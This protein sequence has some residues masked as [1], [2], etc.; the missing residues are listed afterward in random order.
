[1]HNLNYPTFYSKFQI[2]VLIVTASILFS[3]I[4][5]AQSNRSSNQP[6]GVIFSVLTQQNVMCFGGNNGSA[7]ITQPTGGTPP[8]TI[9]W[10]PGNPTGDGTTSITGLTAGIWTCTVTDA[11]GSFASLTFTITQ[12]LSLLYMSLNQTNVGCV[13]AS[14]GSANVT[15]LGGSG[16]YTYLWLPT[17]ITFPTANG[18]AAGIHYCTVTDVNNCQTTRSITIVEQPV[19]PAPTGSATQTLCGGATIANLVATGSNIKW[20][21][22]ATGG[23]ALTANTVLVNGSTYYASQTI[24]TC[25]GA[26]RLAVTATTSTT[27]G[28][29]LAFDGID[30]HITTTGIN[31]SNQSFTIEFWAKRGSL[32]GAAY[33]DI[34]SQGGNISNGLFADNQ[35]L[36][37][38]FLTDDKL[39][40]DFWSN[41]VTST[42]AIIDLVNWHHYALTFDAVTKQ[43]SIYIDGVLNNSRTSSANYSGT[44]V[45]KI[46]TQFNNVN[47]YNGKLDEFR[48]WAR[49]L[50]QTEIQN[51]SIGELPSNTCSLLQNL[52]FNQGFANGDNTTIASVVDSSGNGYNGTLNGFSKACSNSTSNFVSPGAVTSGALLAINLPGASLAFDGVDDYVSTE[53]I[54]ISNQSFS[55][56]FWAKRGSLS[57]AAY[58]D[59]ASQG[60]PNLNQG[61]YLGFLTD[62]K[63]HFDFWGNGVTSTTA[64]TDLVN[65]H[66]YAFT[67]NAATKVQSI[68]IDGVLNNSHLG[69]GNYQGAGTFY[70]GKQFN[71]VNY[72]KGQIDEFRI[73]NNVLN[74]LQIQNQRN[75]EIP[76]NTCGLIQ[77]LH[78]NQGVSDGDNIAIT[79]VTDASGYN[80]NGTLNN[81]SKSCGNS[82]SNFTK[83]SAIVSGTTTAIT[84]FANAPISSSI[85]VCK[86]SPSATISAT[87]LGSGTNFNTYSIGFY[88]A[89]SFQ[90]EDNSAP[91][92]VIS[93]ASYTLP[94]G[95]FITGGTL[96]GLVSPLG[97]SFQSD[98]K[99]GLAGSIVDAA[100][101]GVGAANT[102]GSLNYT[103]PIPASAFTS[104]NGVVDL[105]YWDY[106]NDNFYAPDASFGNWWTPSDPSLNLNVDYCMP[107][108]PIQGTQTF[109]W[110]DSPT[111]GNN[112]GNGN[113][114]E[115]VGS[116][117]LPNTSVPGIYSFY[118]QS[119]ING[120]PNPTRTLVTVTVINPTQPA[121]ALAFDGVDDNIS[122]TGIN[123]A[124]Q[125]FTI[126]FWA[127]RNS[128]STG[129]YQFIASQGIEVTSTGLHI[130][131]RTNNEFSMDFFNDRVNSTA[132]I[133]DVSNWHHYAV[134]YNAVTKLQSLY[135][136]GI[137]NNTNTAIANYSGTGNFYIG[138]YL[139]GLYKFNGQLDEFR[140]WNRALSLA[141]IQNNKN[142]EIATTAC[143]LLLNYHFNQGFASGDNSAITTVTDASGNNNNATLQSF[144]KSCGNSTSNFVTD[145]AVTS[146][147]SCSSAFYSA[148]WNGS[149]NNDFANTANWTGGFPPST[150]TDITIPNTSN[151]PIV[152]IATIANAKSFTIQSNAVLNVYNTL[153]LKSNLT[154]NG[155][156][157]GNGLLELNGSS[158]QTIAGTGSISN[159]TINNA[160]GVSL[161]GAQKITGTLT[162]SLGTLTTNDNLILASNATGT[163]RIA[164]GTSPYITGNV[165]VQRYIPG[166][167]R[168]FRFLGHPFSSPISI[169]QLTDSL[170]I[171]GAIT[172]GNANHFTATASNS[173][174][175]FTYNET[176]AD[177]N[178]NDAGWTSIASSNTAS[179]I[180]VGQGIRVLIR[181]S[182]GQ[183]GSLSGGSYTPNPVTLAMFGNVNQ[184]TIIQNLSYT[185]G[186][187]G[188]WNLIAN[189][190]PSNVDWTTVA[191]NNVNNAI[192]TY[193]PTLSGGSYASYVNGSATNGASQYIESGSAFFV[194]A[195]AASPSLTWHE[196]DKV[197]HTPTN[198]VFRTSSNIH[199]RFSIALVNDAS[200]NSD[201]VIVRFGDDAAT[202]NFDAKYDAENLAG[203]SHDLFVLDDTQKKYSIYHGSELKNATL[204]K[205]EITLGI[206][207]LIAGNYTI[208]TQILNALI[209]NNKAYLKDSE[210]NTLSEITSD[211]SYHFSV[212]IL[213]NNYKRFSIVFNA[214]QLPI[215]N[216]NFSISIAPNPTSDVIHI[217][218]TGLNNHAATTINIINADGKQ[219]QS[220]ELGNVQTGK[221][222]IEAKQLSKG[223][224]LVQII[225]GDSMQTQKLIL[226]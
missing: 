198:S 89:N 161:I 25:E 195:N 217:Y 58:Q 206:N 224:Y 112:L 54:N 84:S 143:G 12:P 60:S 96:W 137:L 145:G 179:T 103:R 218:Y 133:T 169:A 173:P 113:T 219:V 154:N 52:H 36:Y 127:K 104:N 220:K 123:I 86:N 97:Y 118:V 124:N 149:V 176:L 221:C 175:S 29:A 100:T 215:I 157:V 47:Y 91:G 92:S 21:A 130:G 83:L 167:F 208:N 136:D 201:E 122:T 209:G 90:Y 168:K 164:T 180:N 57:G 171:T 24:N 210:T 63:L 44:G 216:N 26:D 189:P 211:L 151:Q 2:K 119:E 194:R 45:F 182:K 213:Q 49:A 82:S 178:A 197:A 158:A 50:S 64:I 28:A 99:L 61:L 223:V 165:T 39:H 101:S 65:W 31:I 203:S 120:C 53:G 67:F 70:I 115:T 129:S 128:L 207:N 20:Y 132:S 140:I 88:N 170:D 109:S 181:G 131:F 110:W 174:S 202:D 85:S 40:F 225:N 62:D 185:A 214:K 74:S 59:I 18:L 146:G 69:N 76:T 108:S 159:L 87:T 160:A 163:A 187:F 212:N 30:D 94:A 23:A 114:F 7:T 35:N 147:V 186:A 13:G 121:S 192:Y 71:N 105:L 199:N 107:E 106:S 142:C 188:G 8:Y 153:S 126:E 156:I 1:M 38:A 11:T 27:Q 204:E 43:Q 68:Y 184:G 191:R 138:Q 139:N 42:S 14:A 141:E 41:G 135:I 15:G 183:A 56:E 166:A 98:I 17:N 152:S 32:S 16:G 80:N 222:S 200:N 134:T 172:G 148:I 22:N 73:W 10:T 111:G 37:I 9:D 79:S 117:V 55:I 78:F 102:H 93:S 77:N 33:Q 72:F 162:P 46:G 226:Q 66:H 196:A 155:S 177:G 193:R 190:Y 4:T 125:S 75:G 48:I 5:N 34:A 205:R 116:T 150:C 51:Y 144:S 81:F 6:G 19:T 3:L 95:A